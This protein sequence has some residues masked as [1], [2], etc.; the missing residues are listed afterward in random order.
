MFD[1]CCG[2]FCIAYDYVCRVDARKEL[3]EK[4]NGPA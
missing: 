4:E 2:N 3:T 1:S